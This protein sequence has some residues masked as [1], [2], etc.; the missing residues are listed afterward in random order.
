M[1]TIVPN[2]APEPERNPDHLAEEPDAEAF[3]AQS[4]QPRRR[5]WWT[6]VA[7]IAIALVLLQLGLYAVRSHSDDDAADGGASETSSAASDV[8]G[9]QGGASGDNPASSRRPRTYTPNPPRKV[10][11]AIM[12][13]NVKHDTIGEDL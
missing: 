5:P 9:E 6:I 8:P 3:E 12:R 2:G 4:D 10:P 13:D 7:I 11:C 1:S